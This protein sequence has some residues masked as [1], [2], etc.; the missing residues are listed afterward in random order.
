MALKNVDKLLI[1][2]SNL[3]Y[4]KLDVEVDHTKD[5]PLREPYNK[6][7]EIYLKNIFFSGGRLSSLGKSFC[8]FEVTKF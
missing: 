8:S 6:Q 7:I 1:L 4:L 2:H 3:I 5:Y